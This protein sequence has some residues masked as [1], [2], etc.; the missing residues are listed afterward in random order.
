M[1]A[2]FFAVNPF[3]VSYYF[4]TYLNVPYILYI[5]NRMEYTYFLNFTFKMKLFILYNQIYELE[6]YN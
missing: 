5:L 2:T 3:V 1:K 4:I 6:I